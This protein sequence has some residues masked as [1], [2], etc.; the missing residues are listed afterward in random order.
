[1]YN[2]LNFQNLHLLTLHIQLVFVSTAVN[3][4]ALEPFVFRNYYHRP[5]VTSHYRG[6]SEA[7]VWET[8]RASSAAPGFFE[9][10]KLAQF[11][12]HVSSAMWMCVCTNTPAY[13]EAPILLTELLPIN[14]LVLYYDNLISK[15][16]E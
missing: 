15:L 8:L 12:H 3:W 5:G 11:V 2:H 7:K 9:E 14:F 13:F 1:M 4:P 10:F 16:N 6:T